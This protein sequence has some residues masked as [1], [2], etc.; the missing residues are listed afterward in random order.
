MV[1]S[2]NPREWI[3]GLD[4]WVVQDGSYDEFAVGETHE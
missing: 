4:P 2:E 3:I 1:G